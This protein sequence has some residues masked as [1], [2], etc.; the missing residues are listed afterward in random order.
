[1]RRLSCL[2]AVVVDNLFGFMD[3][4]LPNKHGVLKL[5]EYV[6]KV[7]LYCFSWHG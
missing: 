2:L 3:S 6:M 1:M 7:I 4:W 5:K